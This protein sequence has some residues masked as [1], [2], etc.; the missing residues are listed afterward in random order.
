V[1]ALLDAVQRFDTDT[2]SASQFGLRQSK[3]AARADDFLC[4]HDIEGFQWIVAPLIRFGQRR[5]S[6]YRLS[7]KSF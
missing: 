6:I 3:L 7:W 2:C 1:F 4:R 5:L